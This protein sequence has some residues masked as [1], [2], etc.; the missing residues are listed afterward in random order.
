MGRTLLVKPGS[1]RFVF[2]DPGLSIGSGLNIGQ[3][4]LHVGP[5]LLGNDF[6]STGII[7]VL[8]R[9]EN[10]FDQRYEMIELFPEPGRRLIVRLE[11]RR[12]STDE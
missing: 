10:V 11:V 12:K 1:P 7:A 8:G 4:L 6:G 2:F 5:G 3:N 9:I